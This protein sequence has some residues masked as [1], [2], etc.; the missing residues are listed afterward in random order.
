MIDVQGLKVFSVVAE[1]LSFS[2]AAE[3]LLM[4]QS[5]VSHQIAKME[6]TFGVL[7]LNRNG[8]SISLTPAG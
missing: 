4:T 3:T 2:R 1:K 6:R 5:A 7:L 8:K